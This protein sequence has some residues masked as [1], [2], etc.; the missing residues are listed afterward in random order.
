M[1]QFANQAELDAYKK[2]QRHKI[3]DSYVQSGARQ[4]AAVLTKA[5]F[6]EQYPADQ[7]ERYTLPA[8]HKFR[9]DLMKAEDIEDKDVAF[10]EATQDLK[11]F[12]VHGD[13]KKTIMFV[14][15]KVKGE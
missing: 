7:W 1:I 5:E 14:R 15:K 8:I 10:K 9:T 13:G 2:A 3:F 12:I 6:D 11:S 4:A